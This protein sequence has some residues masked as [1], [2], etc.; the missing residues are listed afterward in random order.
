MAKDK[1][2]RRLS[3]EGRSFLDGVAHGLRKT[4]GEKAAGLSKY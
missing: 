2:G 3:V 1:T 4:A